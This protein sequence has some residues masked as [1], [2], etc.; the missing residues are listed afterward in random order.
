M[1]PVSSFDP[2]PGL[3]PETLPPAPEALT[4]AEAEPEAIDLAS[5]AEKVWSLLKQELRVEQERS[6]PHRRR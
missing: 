6:R 1:S 4:P 2:P 5:L 3:G